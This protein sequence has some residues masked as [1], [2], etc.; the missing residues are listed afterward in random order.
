VLDGKNRHRK[1]WE[2]PKAKQQVEGKRNG[3]SEEHLSSQTHL[4]IIQKS[5]I[6]VSSVLWYKEGS[7]TTTTFRA[8][9]AL[10]QN[11]EHLACTHQILMFN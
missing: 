3:M 10:F 9:H 4:Q 8:V 11:A 1:C 7:D 6:L 5:A 2:V